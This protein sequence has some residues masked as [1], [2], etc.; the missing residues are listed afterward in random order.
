MDPT[1]DAPPPDPA[2]A[3]DL[4]AR[5]ERLR[6]AAGIGR[7]SR[8]GL[9]RWTLFTGLGAV[10][11]CLVGHGDV[12]LFLAVAALFALAQSWDLRDRGRTGDPDAD[13]MLEPGSMGTFLRAL[14]PLVAPLGGALMF[15]GLATYAR[16][17]PVS[18]AHVAA[19][20]WSIAAA[21]ICAAVA[22]PPLSRQLTRAFVPERVPGYTARLAA[23]I[24]IVL[25]LLPVPFQLLSTDLLDLLRPA[26]KSLVDTGTLLGQLVGE[27]VLALGAIGLWVSRDGRSAVQR[28]GLGPI[29]IRHLVVG[30]LGLAVVMGGNAGMEW[31][32]QHS[33]HALWL[34]DQEMTRW[35]AGDLSTTAAVLLG[36]SAGIGEELLVRGALQPRFGIFWSTLLF[37]SGHVQYSWFGMLTIAFLG[38][39]LGLVRRHANT[40]TC[41]IVHVVYDILAAL[42]AH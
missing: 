17:L 13:G 22:I 20:Q 27:V 3:A 21:V 5:E 14:V 40:T 7:A 38:L 18:K 2:S 26:G 6:T 35:I 31:V 11:A 39:A 33:F 32:E 15:A 9:L 10:V 8:H 34:R 4:E 19:M 29:G 37:A 28:L 36:I 42:G 23:S 41:V 1:Q 24:A 12:A 25:L 30:A 16:T